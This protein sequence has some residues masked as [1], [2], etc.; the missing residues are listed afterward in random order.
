MY[1]CDKISLAAVSPSLESDSDPH[2]EISED[3]S[4]FVCPRHD[5]LNK[6]NNEI[7]HELITVQRIKELEMHLSQIKS[8]LENKSVVL[9]QRDAELLEIQN[10]L[11]QLQENIESLNHDRL[12]YKAEYE[13][14]K[15]NESKIQNDLHEVENVLKKQTEEI[16]E[17][18]EKIQVIDYIYY[19]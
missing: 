19:Y 18:K 12:Y 11:Q 8:E 10:N 5:K 17:F 16:D 1:V 13:I 7:E 6:N 15:M 14:A 9:K 3:S 2:E 4:N